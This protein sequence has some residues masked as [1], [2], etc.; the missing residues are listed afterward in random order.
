MIRPTVQLMPFTSFCADVLRIKLEAGQTVI[1][2]ICFD[3]LEPRQLEGAERELARELFGP[4]EE[5]PASC[6][7]TIVW[8]KGCRLGGTYL[9]SLYQLYLGLTC[10]LDLAPGELAFCVGCAPDK[11]TALQGYRYQ[12]GAVGECPRLKRYVEGSI[13]SESFILRRPDGH[14]VSFEVLAASAGGSSLRGRSYVSLLLD[15]SS[16]FRDPTTGCVNDL[17]LYRAGAPRIV[18]GGRML[19][20]STAFARRGLLW[21]LIEKNY[22]APTTCV[23]AIAPTLLVRPTEQNLRLYA[24]E[25][26]R[27]EESADREFNCIALSVGTSDFIEP[28]SIRQ[29]TDDDLPLVTLP[30]TGDATFSGLDTGFRRD[31]SA[32]VVGHQRYSCPLLVAECFERKPELQGAS[33]KVVLGEFAKRLKAHH[34]RS[35]SAD[36]HY[37]QTVRDE[38]PNYNVVE[39]PPSLAFKLESFTH[40][41]DL[42]RSRGVIIPGGNRRLISQLR[43]VQVRPLSGGGMQIF[44]PRRVGSG[45]HGDICSAFVLMA[46]AANQSGRYVNTGILESAT[47]AGEVDLAI[48]DPYTSYQP[49]CQA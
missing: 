2:K 9:T 15:E 37:I 5:F 13:G 24:E 30:A 20:I 28:E 42:L 48:T 1:C 35:V 43:D 34:C 23:A 3:G 33:P 22:G 19:I 31:P 6:R 16:F 29:C 14:R 32:L 8:L 21:D 12:A 40:T 27:D 49:R 38:L 44:S 10:H 41:R 7:G 45:G 46:W 18:T 39:C 4:V 36:Q 47:S 25:R 11:K 17:E 26:E